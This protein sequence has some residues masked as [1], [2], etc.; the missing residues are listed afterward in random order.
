MSAVH[1]TELQISTKGI[2]LPNGLR[3]ASAA[4]RMPQPVVQTSPFLLPEGTVVDLDAEIEAADLEAYLN[5]RQPSG[6][7]NISIKAENG[8]LTAVATAHIILPVQVGAEGKLEFS[9]GTLNFVPT[10]AEA[11]GIKMPDGLMKEQLAKVN[12]II[13]MR[14]YPIDAKVKAID[15][16]NGRIRLS[17]SLIVTAPIPRREP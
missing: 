17:A 2:V 5:K 6:M 10:R 14:G 11:G 16:G 4:L 3:I 12:P 13:D 7:T 8:L 15:I 1:A 9:K